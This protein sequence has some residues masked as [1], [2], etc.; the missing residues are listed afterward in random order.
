MNAYS[1]EQFNLNA[2]SLFQSLLKMFQLFCFSNYVRKS[3]NSAESMNAQKIHSNRVFMFTYKWPLVKIY[4]FRV[5]LQIDK[6]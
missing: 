1:S 5:S 3:A 6:L 4:N 2:F